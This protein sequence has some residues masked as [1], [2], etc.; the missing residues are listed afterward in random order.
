MFSL[1]TI[2]KWYIY[3]Y[4]WVMVNNLREVTWPDETSH[5]HTLQWVAHTGSSLTCCVD[6]LKVYM[7]TPVWKYQRIN[8]AGCVQQKTTT[9]IGWPNNTV[10]LIICWKCD[11]YITANNGHA[12]R[13]FPSH[14]CCCL[15]II[16]LFLNVLCTQNNK[17]HIEQ[18]LV[19]ELWSLDTGHT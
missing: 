9:S 10:L 18:L 15:T 13:P 6:C 5:R 19:N 2:L 3:I 14:H 12:K 16:G 4:I 1:C 11:K 7:T 8:L 17:H